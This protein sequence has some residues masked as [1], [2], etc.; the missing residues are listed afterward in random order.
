MLPR[1]SP[2]TQSIFL[3]T[4]VVNPNS[5]RGH[6]KIPSPSEDVTPTTPFLNAVR[7]HFP[8][9][10]EKQGDD[11]IEQAR[12]LLLSEVPSVVEEDDLQAIEDKISS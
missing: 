4:L 5:H 2:L 11:L 8:S 6:Q 1:N 10:Q 9:S 3:L 7:K 12:D